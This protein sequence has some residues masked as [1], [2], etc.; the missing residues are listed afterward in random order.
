MLSWICQ[1]EHFFTFHQILPEQKI[2]IAAFY[3]T[4][5]ALQ[6]FHWLCATQQLSTWEVFAR[7]AE[8]RFGPS[9]FINHEAQLFK[10]RQKTTLAAYLSEFESLSTRVPGL[11]STSLLNCFLSGL[12]DDIQRD[13]YV[14]RPP[15]LHEAMGMAKLMEDKYNAVRQTQQR[16]LPP[17]PTPLALPPNTNAPPYRALPAPGAIPIKRLTPAEMAARR[18][19]GLCFNCDAK[20]TRGHRCNPPQFLCLMTDE[21]ATVDDE[22]ENP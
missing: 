12:R 9:T 20:F 3:M 15:S 22:V 8:L 21:E 6:W 11:S 1:I 17:K 14:L 18:E 13:L 16:F 7:Q 5:D 10:L 2:D 4:G 19:R